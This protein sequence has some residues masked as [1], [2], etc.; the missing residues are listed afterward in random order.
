MKTK[1]DNNEH[2]KGYV[3]EKTR[4]RYLHNIDLVHTQ[5]YTNIHT[6]THALDII[7]NLDITLA[8]KE[9]KSIIRA[10]RAWK[11]HDTI[12]KKK[13]KGA[14]VMRHA[15]QREEPILQQLLQV[16][17]RR[18]LPRVP[19]AVWRLT[20]G[21]IGVISTLLSMCQRQPWWAGFSWRSFS[22][23]SASG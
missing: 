17:W 14:G 6:Y 9:Q 21:S 3:T 11:G 15:V 12:S 7:C 23:I 10:R 16:Y 19:F 13:Q 22:S 18:S 2:T 1:K 20:C 4:F 8:Q 5:I